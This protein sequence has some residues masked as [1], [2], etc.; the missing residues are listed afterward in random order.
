M[1]EAA[2]SIRLLAMDVDGVLTSGDVIYLDAGAEIKVFNIQD[3]LGISAARHAGLGIAV[4]TGRASQAVERRASELGVIHVRQGC[5]D[6]GAALR[7]LMAETGLRREEV[8]FIGDD[9]NDIPAFR[10]CGWKVAVSNAS[11]DLKVLA[12]HV[13]ERQGGHGAVREVIELILQCQGK[14]TRAVEEYL[15]DLEQS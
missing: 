7:Q 3:G 11:Q 1:A 8:A 9:L 13:T 15:R 4:I 10:E 5:R 14:W 2:R 6:K 12:D